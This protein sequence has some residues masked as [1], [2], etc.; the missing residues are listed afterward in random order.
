MQESNSCTINTDTLS[1]ILSEYLNVTFETNEDIARYER[2]K[3][4]LDQPDL[5]DAKVVCANVELVKLG[6]INARQS[7]SKKDEKKKSGTEL[8]L[9]LVHPTDVKKMKL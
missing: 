8:C 2:L 7:Q 5:D 4:W 9:T 3:F 1:N 6:A